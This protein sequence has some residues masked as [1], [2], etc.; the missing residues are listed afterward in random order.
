LT[1]ILD[2]A[3]L[4]PPAGLPLDQAFANFVRYRA[5]PERWMLARFVVPA[6]RLA[7]LGA[8]A[9]QGTAEAEPYPLAVLGR[10]GAN[11]ETFLAGLAADL[12]AVDAFRRQ[13]GHR[14]AAG[15]FE[16]RLP[17]EAGGRRLNELVSRAAAA[18][19]GRGLRPFFEPS[20][21]GDW[22]SGIAALVGAIVTFDEAGGGPAGFKLRAGGVVA[23]AFPSPEQVA[24]AVIACRDVGL[25]FKAT[26]G[27][28]HPLR[29]YDPGVQTRMH[30]FFNLFGAAILAHARR[31]DN[32]AVHAILVDEAAGHFLFDGRRFAWQHLSATVE[33]LAAARRDFAISFGSCSFDEPRAD[34]RALGYLAES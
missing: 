5:Q 34:L 26:A 10:G 15:V 19:A 6:G 29:H 18:L 32:G 24:F 30:G 16:T 12:E 3:G 9:G 23:S 8:M 17:A 4:F 25:P 27:L 11:R 14:F 33:E 1:G 21:G 28:H 31:L 22:R 13:H 20:L 2:Y 7:E